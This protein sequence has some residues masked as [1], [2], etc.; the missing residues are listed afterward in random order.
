MKKNYLYSVMAAFMMLFAASCSQEEIVS[1]NDGN[2]SE[3][4]I[5]VG[6]P[7]RSATTRAGMPEY[8]GY[9]RRCI[10]Q[11]VDAEGA[12]IQGEK[13]RQAVAVTGETVTFSFPEPEGA[14]SVV[15]WAD[16]VTSLEND[17]IYNTKALPTIS[18]SGNK[19]NM[20]KPYGDAFCGK[21][22]QGTTSV[23]LKRPFN[24]IVV[25]SEN[26]AA[27][28]E[29]THV[30]TGNFAVP[31][32]Y[33]IFGGTC[34]GTTKDIR[35]D[36]FTA[37]S[38]SATGEWFSFFIFAPA[39]QMSTELTLP[40]TL[41]KDA[42][43]AD[44]LE[45]QVKA[46]GLPADDNMIGNV[47]I[48][49]IPS[50]PAQDIE[51]QVSFDDKFEN[52]PAEPVDPSVIK[53]GSYINAAGQ[54]V[55][56]AA[57]AVAIVFALEAIGGDLPANYDYPEDVQGKTIKG[58]AVAIENTAAARQQIIAAGAN[59]LTFSMPESATNGTQTTE[60]LLSGI[61]AEAKFTEAYTNWT[62]AHV[63][64]GSNLSE[65]YIPTFA[66]LEVF[67]KMLFTVGDNVPA[68]SDAFK[69]LPEFAHENGKLFDRDPINVVMYASSTI[70]ANGNISAMTFN[71]DGT[72]QAGQAKVDG[73]SATS[74]L[75]RPFL[76]IFE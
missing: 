40:I 72:A 39:D 63:L 16:Y 50:E 37:I 22:G 35:L 53:V 41:S 64:T 29:Y 15:F 74:T 28:G 57:E 66:Q 61:G 52:G 9:T 34:D 23:T 42:E 17:F 71:A 13:M 27:F 62:R 60:A 49:E 51:V 55:A 54:A 19:D 18:Y 48:P 43:G 26:T 68:G 33:S 56:D 73:S 11:V 70:N 8:E 36:A 3:V 2:N 30:K 38:N 46:T 25:G 14:Y 12:A 1:G 47:N 5:L 24:K 44:K 58:Y 76:T 4:T 69:A 67:T 7:G 45:I 65:W 31:D 75:C 59:K 21:V 10:M 20:F 6:V 32:N